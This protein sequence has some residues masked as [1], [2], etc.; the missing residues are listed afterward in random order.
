MPKR[1]IFE[2][3]LRSVIR[4]SVRQASGSGGTRQVRKQSLRHYKTRYKINSKAV[5][6]ASSGRYIYPVS[7]ESFYEDNFQTLRNVFGNK[8]EVFASCYLVPEP[9]NPWSSD[10]VAVVVQE[11]VVGHIPRHAANYFSTFLSG[12]IGKCGVRMYF[13]SFSGFHAVELDC[14]FPPRR[15]G[16]SSTYKIGLLGEGLAP[17]YTMDQ[18][19]TRDTELAATLNLGYPSS[20][21]LVAGEL[22]FGKGSIRQGYNGRPEITDG[23]GMVIGYPYESIS[24]DFN[25][26]VRALG[27]E[28]LIR[29]MLTLKEN[30]K[31]KLLLDASGLPKFKRNKY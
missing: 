6:L 22:Q 7:G 30:G 12:E 26:F 29:Y 3:L 11:L 9:K 21:K 13:N 1:S 10:S 2:S 23:G 4:E 17:T 14:A 28:V 19:T 16:D 18:V 31:P 5:Q 15:D 20:P 27:G 25:T 24:Y 8:E